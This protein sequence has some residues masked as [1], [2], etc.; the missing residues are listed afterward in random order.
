VRVAIGPLRL[1]DLQPGGCRELLPAEVRALQ[2]AG[3]KAPRPKAPSEPR[4]P[5]KAR[6]G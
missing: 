2:K 4:H 3:A 1:G 6:R 5:R